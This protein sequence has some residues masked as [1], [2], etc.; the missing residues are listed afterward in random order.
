MLLV[1]LLL[2]MLLTGGAAAQ[3]LPGAE[4]ILESQALPAG[5]QKVFRS[6]LVTIVEDQISRGANP[7]WKHRDC[8]G[9]V[10]Y[11]VSES[12][13]RH[14]QHWRVANGFVGRPLPAELELTTG[15]RQTMKL[16]SDSDGNR[17]HF[18][19]ALPLI[20]QNA[21]FLGKTMDRI[22]PGDLLFFDQGDEQHLMIWTG[23]R[24]VYHNGHRPERGE[25]SRDNGLRAVT[26]PELMKWSD[27]RWQPSTE[28]PNFIGY[29]RLNFLAKRNDR[30]TP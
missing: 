16:W 2:S 17:S 3:G 24:I 11:A 10:R 5:Q 6:W 14:D 19:R 9:L 18:V 4:E 26:F 20:Q 27:T 28:N 15:Q 22:E 23:R 12:L 30:G 21:V 7:R 1:S 25:V 8:A 13:S 29:Y